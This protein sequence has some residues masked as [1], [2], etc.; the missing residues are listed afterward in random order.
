MLL[1]IATANSKPVLLK[2]VPPTTTRTGSTFFF[3]KLA[4]YFS[5]PENA[6]L[7]FSVQGLPNG[8]GLAMDRSSGILSGH[9]TTSDLAGPVTVLV[10]AQD[11]RQQ[12]V[13]A[14]FTLHVLPEN[15]PPTSSNIPPAQAVEGA[16]FTLDLAGFFSDPDGDNLTF[17]LVAGRPAGARHAH[18]A[19]RT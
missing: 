2:P 11:E 12:V 3:M 6:T 13:S 10:L 19:P 15:R 14:N 17:A 16:N 5:D 1:Q 7:A 4:S 8:T 18:T 9:P